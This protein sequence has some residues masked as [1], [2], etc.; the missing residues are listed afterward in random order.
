MSTADKWADPHA[1]G[2]GTVK[3]KEPERKEI[4]KLMED[5]I[6]K[7]GPIETAPITSGEESDKRIRRKMGDALT[8]K[9]QKGG[10]TVT[11]KMTTSQKEALEL[12]RSGVCTVAAIAKKQ[13]T[14]HSNV[15]YSLA[16]LVANGYAERVG[17]SEYKALDLDG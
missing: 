2:G 11:T 1:V 14:S 10:K 16:R 3:S 17:N 8:I 12:L 5:Y 9:R 13:K 4:A 7:H 15:K 6:A